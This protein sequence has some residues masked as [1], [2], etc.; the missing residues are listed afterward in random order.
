MTDNDEKLYKG[1]T[2]KCGK[3]MSSLA[4]WRG[5]GIY[6][7]LQRYDGTFVRGR[8]EAEHLM[9]MLKQQWVEGD[10]D[11]AGGYGCMLCGHVWPAGPDGFPVGL[12]LDH[13]HLEY[14]LTE[15]GGKEQWGG[16]ARSFVCNETMG[17]VGE[18]TGCNGKM[19]SVDD[20]I[21][22]RG[23]RTG[24]VGGTQMTAGCSVGDGQIERARAPPVHGHAPVNGAYYISMGFVFPAALAGRLYG[25]G[26]R[27]TGR[28][29]TN[30]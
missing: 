14:I 28:P 13:L 24:V 8:L 3:K 9:A 27:V 5:A 4:T 21:E 22:A 25:A 29:V 6:V 1:L 15:K 10:D 23:M 17:T 11:E 7:L 18:G 12:A 16:V 30:A 19:G 2:E 26:T 20:D